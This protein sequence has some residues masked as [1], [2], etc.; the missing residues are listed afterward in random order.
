MIIPSIIIASVC[1]LY[2]NEI[3]NLLY[4]QPSSGKVFSTLIIGFIGISITY[5]YGTLLT[6]NGNLK[7]LNIMALL[8][9]IMNFSLNLIL[10]PHFKAMALR[11]PVV[12]TQSVA[13]CGS[14]YT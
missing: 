7:Y 2:G 12:M 9:V 1:A 11:F 5:L 13:G 8:A 6:A 3:M 4:H 10:I 14:N